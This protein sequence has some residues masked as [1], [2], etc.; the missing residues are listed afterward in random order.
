MIERI[1]ILYL[2]I[3]I[4]SE[5]WNIT[6]CLGLGQETMVF[7]VRL[8]IFLRIVTEVILKKKITSCGLRYIWK[9]KNSIYFG[10]HVKTLV[11]SKIEIFSISGNKNI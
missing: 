4:K 7:A 11:L 8:S 2:I 5:V 9:T 6:H 10:E 1:Y 3:I